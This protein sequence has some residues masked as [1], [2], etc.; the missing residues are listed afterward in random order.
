MLF[1]SD[2][3]GTATSI[4]VTDSLPDGFVYVPGSIAG[5]NGQ[6]ASGAPELVWMIVMLGGQGNKINKGFSQK[7]V[8]LTFQAVLVGNQTAPDD[9][10]N[11]V[12][13]TAAEQFDPDSTPGND[14]TTEDDDA[15][16]WPAVADLSLEKSV[17]LL[18]DADSNGYVSAGDTVRFTLTVSNTG[19][20]DATNVSV[21]DALPAGYDFV[22]GS[23]TGG[24]S[25]DESSDP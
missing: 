2:G 8:E 16:A 15:T 19:P 12:Q 11:Y 25:Q 14:S 6:N 4:L 10:V 3:P 18:T 22:T 13:V 23:M 20:A 5:G 24:M 21:T 7:S 17:A 1:R 9:Y